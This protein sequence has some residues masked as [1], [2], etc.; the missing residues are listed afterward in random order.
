MP[1]GV[2]NSQGLG[3][4]VTA[5][6]ETVDLGPDGRATQG[7]KVLFTTTRGIHGSVFVPRAH[8]NPANV[9]AA[10]AGYVQQLH[11]VHDLKA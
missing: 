10:I 11:E 2:P 7:I 1:A 5:Q 4:E 8:Y 9:R 6:Q 3:W